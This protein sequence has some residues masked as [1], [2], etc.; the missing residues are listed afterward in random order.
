M[1]V[2]MYTLKYIK[3]IFYTTLLQSLFIYSSKDYEDYTGCFRKIDIISFWNDRYHLMVCFGF[4]VYQP[5]LI[6]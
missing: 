4:M 1:Y 5:L 3:S 6:I 2:C